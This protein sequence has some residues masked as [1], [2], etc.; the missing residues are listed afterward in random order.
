MQET[1]KD[2]LPRQ[3]DGWWTREFNANNDLVFSAFTQFRPTEISWVRDLP[4][5]KHYLIIA[6]FYVNEAQAEKITGVK[7]YKESTKRLMEAYGGL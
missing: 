2:E 7:S 3:P 5:K 1:R 6:P 4:N